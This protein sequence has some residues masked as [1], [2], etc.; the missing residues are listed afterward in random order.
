MESEA[1]NR[2]KIS[3]AIPRRRAIICSYDDSCIW[4]GIYI[5][6]TR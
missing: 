3:L 4:R 5:P 2:K 1:G 6:G